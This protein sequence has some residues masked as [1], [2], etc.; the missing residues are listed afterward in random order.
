MHV[1]KHKKIFSFGI[2]LTLLTLAVLPNIT[3]NKINFQ[4]QSKTVVNDQIK[5][6]C[7]PEDNN[8][9]YDLLIITPTK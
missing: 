8:T 1:N 4:E 3:A 9:I 7:D 5:T 2:I 6:T